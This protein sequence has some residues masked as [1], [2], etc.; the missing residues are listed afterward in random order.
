MDFF[1]GS[2][3]L[4]DADFQARVLVCRAHP[5]QSILGNRV[6]VKRDAFATRSRIG[7]FYSD[8]L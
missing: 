5:E 3:F 6:V 4:L 8:D 7:I 2:Y 1:G